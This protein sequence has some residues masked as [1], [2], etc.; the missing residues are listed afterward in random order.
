[1]NLT[2]HAFPNQLAYQLANSIHNSQIANFKYW[3]QD[4]GDQVNGEA[5][6]WSKA[7]WGDK[8]VSGLMLQPQSQLVG[9]KTTTYAV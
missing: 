4:E 5:E 3:L 8:K 1:M 7:E 2:K 9:D 6:V